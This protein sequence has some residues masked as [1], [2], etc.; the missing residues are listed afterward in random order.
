LK[1]MEKLVDRHTRDEILGLHPLH[2]LQWYQFA[3]KPDKS[4]E[5]ALKYVTSHTEDAVKNRGCT[6]SLLRYWESF[7][8]HLTQSHNRRRQMA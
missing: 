2:P 5:T 8:Q 3:Y 7:W 4:T 1:T 6:C